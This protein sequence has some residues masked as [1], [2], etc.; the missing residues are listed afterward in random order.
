[1]NS[2][3]HEEKINFLI[4]FLKE[5][6][7]ATY[8]L[9]RK[10]TKIH[11]ERLFKDGLQEAYKMANLNLPRTFERK[12]KLERK[13]KIIN[14]IREHPTTT[15][16]DIK[17]DLKISIS[18]GFSSIKEAFENAN[19]PYL[20]EEMIRLRKMSKEEKKQNVFTLLKKR[21]ESTFKEIMKE[22]NIN[23]YKLFKN[24]EQ[25]YNEGK[26][27]KISGHEKRKRKK[28]KIIIEFIKKHPF[29][30]QR[31]I[32]KLCKTRIQSLFPHGIFGAYNEA[33]IKFPFER[34]RIHG[35]AI[36]E[37]NQRAKD[38]ESEIAKRLLSYGNIHRL[39]KTKRG[40]ADII[41]ERKDKK[42]IIEIKDYLNKEIC[43]SD[44]KQLNRYL[45]DCNC[46]IGFL[47]CHNKPLKDTFLIGENKLIILNDS[48]LNKIPEILD[49]G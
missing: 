22:I 4:K 30:T 44:I 45:E 38:F 27:E 2:K 5:N 39:V 33:E 13:E 18:S 15:G 32:N 7:K 48:E 16:Q 49:R 3:S 14:Y 1:M 23:P 36:K 21:P 8:R 26:I 24:L 47:I 37:I 42:V 25:A 11:P 43:E 10:K 31:E 40:I 35:S 17:K 41:L 46:N 6:P 12:D 29:S 28:Q 20:R 9:I 19:I 34:L